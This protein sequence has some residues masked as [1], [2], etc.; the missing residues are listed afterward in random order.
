[1]DEWELLTFPVVLGKEKRLF[2]EGAVPA[3]LKLVSSSVSSTGVVV[4]RYVPAGE[5][6]AG[7]FAPEQWLVR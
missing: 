7:S 6:V 5:L 4:G 3:A 2:G 1:M